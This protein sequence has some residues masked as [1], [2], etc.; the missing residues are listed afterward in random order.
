M[1]RFDSDP[2]LFCGLISNGSL[3]MLTTRRIQSPRKY[4]QS[5]NALAREQADRASRD[6]D[7]AGYREPGR[8]SP[9]GGTAADR[10]L[11]T[12]RTPD[13]LSLPGYREGTG[14]C[15]PAGQITL[16]FD[17]PSACRFRC[18]ALPCFIYEYKEFVPSHLTQKPFQSLDVAIESAGRFAFCRSF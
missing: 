7:L 14:Q 13:P 3:A 16:L 8:F 1:R 2:R 10:R 11:I 9:M 15:R 17:E 12:G 18:I 6:R 4:R 5:A